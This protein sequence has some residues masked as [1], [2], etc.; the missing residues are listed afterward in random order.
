MMSDAALAVLQ[1]AKEAFNTGTS[2]KNKIKVTYELD[3]R[4]PRTDAVLSTLQFK[5]SNPIS[6]EKANKI[7]DE[8]YPLIASELGN[9]TAANIGA[10]LLEKQGIVKKIR[11]D[12]DSSFEASI[13]TGMGNIGNS[14]DLLSGVA[15]A[16][17]LVRTASGRLSSQ[18]N[19]K[20]SLELLMKENLLNTMTSPSAGRGINTP[21]RNRTGRFVNST[22]IE[23]VLVPEEPNNNISIYYKYMVYPYQVFDPNNTQSPEMGLSSRMRNP[24][25]LIGDAIKGAARTLLNKKYRATIKQVM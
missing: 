25:K 20:A 10:K 24:Q 4:D 13:D 18:M 22:E 6:D 21:L 16:A 23:S 7:I 9:R 17:G 14:N 19:I 11:E 1:V 12:I 3:F 5:L 2:S 8:M 15:G